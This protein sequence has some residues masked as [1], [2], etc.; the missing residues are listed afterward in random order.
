M[1]KTRTIVMLLCVAVAFA[2]IYSTPKLARDLT[3]DMGFYSGDT[4][5]GWSGGSD[6]YDYG[7]SSNWNDYDDDDYNWSWG[8][9]DDDDDDYSYNSS[10]SSNYNPTSIKWWEGL[11]AFILL[12]AP[13]VIIVCVIEHIMDYG[14]PFVG[15][16]KKNKVYLNKVQSTSVPL[17]PISSYKNLDPS[18]DENE[19]KEKISN[20]YIQMQNAWTA[21]DISPVQPY[22]TDALFKQFERQLDS[23]I[24]NHQTNYVDRIAVLG[25]DINGYRQSGDMDIIV[26]TVNTRIVDYIVDDKTRNVVSGSKTKEKFMTYEYE[27]C[28]KTG[29]M[30]NNPDK[31]YSVKCPNCGSNV[32][33]NASAKCPYCGTVLRIKNSDWAI[34]NIKGI[35]QRTV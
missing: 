21:K 19:F 13:F 10:G 5:Y 1:K 25:V 11:I 15:K 6:N 12:I 32:D 3:T 24:N 29:I 26:V 33:I 34:Q 7:G 4:D 9:D 18:F 30:S 22:F 23:L 17:R 28:R 2:I 27:L 16:R 14:L 35:A 20:I 8:D 31:L